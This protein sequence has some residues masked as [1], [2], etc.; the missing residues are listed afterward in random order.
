[1]IPPVPCCPAA[2]SGFKVLRETASLQRQ[3]CSCAVL[4]LETAG[5]GRWQDRPVGHSSMLP[6][7]ATAKQWAL[8]R[9]AK[10]NAAFR[11]Q[12]RMATVWQASPFSQALLFVLPGRVTPSCCECPTLVMQGFENKPW[13][14]ACCGWLLLRAGAEAHLPHSSLQVLRDTE[15]ELP[16]STSRCELPLE[17]MAPTLAH[18][19]SSQ[20]DSGSTTSGSD[21]SSQ[22]TEATDQ[23]E[24]DGWG[25]TGWNS[26]SY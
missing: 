18:L 1:M 24:A 8:E 7:I 11:C 19:G 26:T 22:G 14:A 12:P 15:C 25:W 17:Q 21:L 23:S 6:F 3:V 16:R 5:L 10:L 13:L 4:R 20:L 2:Y 9:E